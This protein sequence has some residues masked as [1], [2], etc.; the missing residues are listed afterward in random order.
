MQFPKGT[1]IVVTDGAKL[2]L[3]RNTGDE[4]HLQ[5]EELAA[6]KITATHHGS[7]TH[8]GAE[9]NPAHRQI[10]EDSHAAGTV[11]WLN[12][13]V[14]AGRIGT[15]YVIAPPRTLGELRPHYHAELKKKLL[16]ELAKEH[17][18]DGL[19]ELRDLLAAA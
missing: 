12:A 4:L 10:A 6:P 1:T 11:H 9:G 13:E 3:F 19:K 5:L 16:G 15:L 2:R 7:A 17:T 14:L 8:H 18:N